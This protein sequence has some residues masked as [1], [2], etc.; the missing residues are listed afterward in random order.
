MIHNQWVCISHDSPFLIG[1]KDWNLMGFL[2]VI[3]E[4]FVLLHYL[5]H[6]HFLFHDSAFLSIM[7]AFR[8]RMGIDRGK[9]LLQIVLLKDMKIF[10]YLLFIISFDL[11]FIFIC[12]FEFLFEIMC[13]L[14][15]C[16]GYR[17]ECVLFFSMIHQFYLLFLESLINLLNLFLELIFLAFDIISF[18][19][20]FS[21]SPLTLCLGII[22][23]IPQFL[24]LL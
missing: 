24:C 23:I 9:W 13:I 5:L 11:S 18:L 3:P 21:F 6:N 12:F 10:Y 17:S 15:M 16:C 20:V 2:I 19:L 4:L 1:C 7:A 8:V 22:H 14:N